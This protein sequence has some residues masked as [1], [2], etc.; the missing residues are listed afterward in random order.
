MEGET[1]ELSEKIARDF[2]RVGSEKAGSVQ[3]L[4]GGE[5]RKGDGSFLERGGKSSGVKRGVS[6]GASTR[7]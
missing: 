5:V 7:G 1:G 4:Q 6:I 3:G 2:T